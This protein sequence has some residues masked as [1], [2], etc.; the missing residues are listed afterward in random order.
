MP[1]LGAKEPDYAKELVSEKACVN[2]DDR[3]GTRHTTRSQWCKAT[4]EHSDDIVVTTST[5]ARLL[6]G[7]SYDHHT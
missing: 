4:R 2:S 5:I 6:R 1:D 7:R 3:N